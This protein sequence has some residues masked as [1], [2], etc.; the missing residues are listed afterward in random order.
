LA[1]DEESQ[2]QEPETEWEPAPEL[3]DTKADA[4][5]LS[6]KPETVPEPEPKPEIRADPPKNEEE[7]VSQAGEEDSD[8]W[9]TEDSNAGADMEAQKR[10]FG[11]FYKDPHAEPTSKNKPLHQEEAFGTILNGQHAASPK[12]TLRLRGNR[13]DTLGSST[14]AD[15][16]GEEFGSRS[17]PSGIYDD[18]DEEFGS[19][20]RVSRLYSNPGPSQNKR[21]E[22]WLELSSGL[23]LKQGRTEN[24]LAATRDLRRTKGSSLA[25]PNSNG[26]S[27]N[28]RA[29]PSGPPSIRGGLWDLIQMAVLFPFIATLCVYYSLHDVKDLLFAFLSRLRQRRLDSTR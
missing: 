27:V 25:P 21:L 3:L 7:V 5:T 18:D 6:S 2:V 8:G 26:R 10:V 15:E 16:D 14:V 11:A 20:N 19:R 22:D 17:Y 4:E 29:V 23:P 13:R 1:R 24:G 28:G 12:S 9:E